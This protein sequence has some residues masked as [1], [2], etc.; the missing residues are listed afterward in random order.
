[1]TK[2]YHNANEIIVAKEEECQFVRVVLEST[3]I[4][5]ANDHP[6]YLESLLINK[7]NP[8]LR[9]YPVYT[10]GHPPTMLNHPMM[11]LQAPGC[12]WRTGSN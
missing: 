4:L 5:S 12:I 9:Q 7:E 1:M 2:F 3:T 10:T 6:W 8:P 11:I